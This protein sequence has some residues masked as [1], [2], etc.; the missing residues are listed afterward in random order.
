ML[1]AMLDVLVAVNLSRTE[2]AGL[3]AVRLFDHIE[4]RLVDGRLTSLDDPPVGGVRDACE[5]VARLID[6]VYADPRTWYSVYPSK[7]ETAE[8]LAEFS[9]LKKKVR[10]L[11]I[12][13]AIRDWEDDSAAR[14][15]WVATR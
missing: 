12:V 1:T 5:V 14:G 9:D 7:S 11:H 15:N 8:V 4:L 10:Q 3:G 2:A 6:C 13:A